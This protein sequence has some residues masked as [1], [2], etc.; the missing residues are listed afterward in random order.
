MDI[1]KYSK[2]NIQF[3]NDKISLVLLKYLNQVQWETFLD[4]G[5]GDGSI[6]KSLDQNGFFINKKVYAVDISE[7]RIKRVQKLNKNFECF[8]SDASDIVNISDKTIDF[9]TS[10]QV[11][12]H[13][14]DDKAMI[15]EIKRILNSGGVVYLSTVFK[16]KYGWYFYRCNGKWTLDPT[17]VRE[18][19]KDNQLL[20]IIKENNFKIMYTNKSLIR[21]PVIDFFLRK[22]GSERDIFENSF[23]RFL[24][25]LRIPIFGYYNW[26]IVFKGD[27]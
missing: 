17:H 26:E 9:V 11:I 14:A 25:K 24:R 1:K 27:F 12:E 4:L 10:T 23:L 22:I 19:S 3:Y 13:V 20:D 21:M 6:L 8:V 16:K 18:Y 15:E 5:C 7:I 2:K